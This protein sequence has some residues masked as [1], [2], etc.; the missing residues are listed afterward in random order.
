MHR[1][2]HDGLAI[3]HELLQPDPPRGDERGH[4]PFGSPFSLTR[5]VLAKKSHLKFS[6]Q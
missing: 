4:N 6:K 3:E 5:H 2:E 1:L